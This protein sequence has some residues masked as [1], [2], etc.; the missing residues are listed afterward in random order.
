[1]TDIM[2]PA[3]QSVWL[4]FKHHKIS[5][6]TLGA[7]ILGG[8]YREW[9][10]LLSCEESKLRLGSL[11]NQISKATEHGSRVAIHG[12]FN[13]DLDRG[14]ERTYYMAT[15]AKSLA[16]CTAT[17]SLETHATS[18][19]F[20][21]F[22]NF[23]PHPAGDLSRPPGDVA[24]PAGGGPSPAG[25]GPSPAG[26]LPSPAG[27]GQNPTGDFHKYARLDHVYTKSTPGWTTSTPRGSFR[28]RR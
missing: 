21:S 7:F 26:G 9:T 1:M 14:E 5:S 23:V 3:I 22:G 2:D 16:E 6:A 17:A 18:P 12:D 19:T 4:H 10:P 15:L 11:L 8:I 13:V 24:S 28:S 27:D 25:G 20:R